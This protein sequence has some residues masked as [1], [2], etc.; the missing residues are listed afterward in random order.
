M[1]LT[2]A[3]RKLAFAVIVLILAGLGAWLIL[4][5]RHPAQAADAPPAQP[6]AS[7]SA[8]QPVS[9]PAST[10]AGSGPAGQQGP[11]ASPSPGGPVSPSTVP[12]IYRWLPFTQAE[13][14]TAAARAVAFGRDYG[15][16]SYTGDAASYLAP[17][18]GLVTSQL[19][20]VI[21]RAYATPGVAS[22]RASKQQVSTGSAAIT[23]LRAF[24]HSSITFVVAV[25][26]RV[27]DT[28]GRSSSTTDYAV[29]VTGGAAS[30]QVS[31]VELA[32]AGN[33]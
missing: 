5:G 9:A 28:S 27:T 26:E 23:S 18:R 29:T 15:T 11:A 6:A 8:S 20:Q 22:E 1:E 13:L 4:P 17:M 32:S 24:G 33:A 21:G 14:S 10:P 3:Q 2:P 31:D 25:T 16:F 19:A 30:W 12:D 7:P